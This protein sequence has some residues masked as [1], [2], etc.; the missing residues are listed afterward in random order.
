MRGASTFGTRPSAGEQPVGPAEEA[1]EAAVVRR[2]FVRG[3]R[4]L[5]PART[6][7]QVFVDGLVSRFGKEVVAVPLRHELRNRRSRIA[8][9]AEVTSACRTCFDAGGNA[10][11][12]GEIL[13]IDAI[14]AQRA[15]AHDA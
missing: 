11:L 6:R 8:E 1:I 7:R 4:W 15:L 3:R 14:D 13:V 12:G 5:L 2:G 9:V 10:V